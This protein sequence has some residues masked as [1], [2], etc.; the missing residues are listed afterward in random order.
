[1]ASHAIF[2]IQM[3][4]PE[5]LIW[6]QNHIYFA[7]NKMEHF[8]IHITGNE[9]SQMF[10]TVWSGCI[11]YIFKMSFLV[12]IYIVNFWETQRKLWGSSWT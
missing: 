12:R 11:L 4:M 1:M 9:H 2:Y 5:K 10:L 3:Q 6:Y 8:I 7:V